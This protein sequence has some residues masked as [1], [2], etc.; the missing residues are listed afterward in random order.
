MRSQIAIGRVAGALYLA[1]VL[2]GI[3][4]LAYVPSRI[5]AN[6]SIES[7]IAHVTTSEQL[8]RSGI[9]SFLVNQVA[10]L[11][12]ALAMF[13]LFRDVNRKAAT[14]MAA[15][16][17]AGIPLALVGV[18]HRLDI[19]ALIAP[20][21]Q[22]QTGDATVLHAQV[23]A[24]LASYRSTLLV[25]NL[26]WGLWLFPLGCLVIKSRSIPRLLG[27]FLILGCVGYCINVFGTILIP[28]Y[29]DSAFSDYATLPAAIGEIGTALWLLVMGAKSRQQGGLHALP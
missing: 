19:L 4:S 5:P 23:A 10:F 9:A 13:A 29:R 15:L 26:F 1:V 6:G 2:T 7:F 17:C 20:D 18:A 12:L 25:T 22:A 21:V 27:A 16:A 11:L 28:G 3:F 14:T 8:Y 24:A